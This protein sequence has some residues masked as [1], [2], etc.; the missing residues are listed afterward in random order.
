[1]VGIIEL[2]L[3][4]AVLAGVGV[5]IFF[6]IKTLNKPKP[7]YPP[8]YPPYPPQY[9]QGGPQGPYPPQQYPG[10]PPQQPPYPPQGWGN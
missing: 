2:L 1:M 10:Q 5:G 7:P 4:M 3:I 9:P 6:L 8:Q